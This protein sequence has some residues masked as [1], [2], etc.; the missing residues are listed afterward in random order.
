MAELMVVKVVPFLPWGKPFHLWCR[1]LFLLRQTQNAHCSKGCHCFTSTLTAISSILQ[2]SKVSFCQGSSLLE[3]KPHKTTS[4]VSSFTIHCEGGLGMHL[5]RG[6]KDSGRKLLWQYKYL[7]RLHVH[8]ESWDKRKTKQT[9]TE[10]AF[11]DQQ[12]GSPPGGFPQGSVHMLH[13]WSKSVLHAQVWFGNDQ[14]GR[15]FQKWM[16]GINTLQKKVQRFVAF[17]DAD[18]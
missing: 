12:I 8:T 10:V 4:K 3:R 11:S 15:R 16:N 7:C 1:G 2:M 14:E 9:N 5:R 13:K 17:V 18:C 6:R